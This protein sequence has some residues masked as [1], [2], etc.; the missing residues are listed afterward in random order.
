MTESRQHALQDRI[1]T[2]RIR[3]L[4]IEF[5]RR[6]GDALK[7]VDRV[8]IDIWPREIVGIIGESGSGKTLT[9][10]AT[11]RM[12]PKRAVI[13]KGTMHLGETSLHDRSER[14]MRALRGDR[15]ALIP[16]DAMQ[17]LNPTMRIGRQVGEPL[18]LHSGYSV[19]SALEAAGKLLGSVHIREP[20]KRVLEYPHQ[21]SGGMQQRAMIA[22]GLALNPQLIIAD[23]PTTAL[24]VT[25]QAQVLKLLREIRD[26]KG[27][28]ILFITHDLGVVAE[29]C[30]WVYVM[31]NG[32]IV[33]DGAVRQIFTAPR[34]E[35]TRMLLDATPS[36]HTTPAVAR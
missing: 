30:D 9:S 11:L 12:L 25:V 13:A 3:D 21:Y 28:S 14:E 24:D 35:Y 8:S 15:I 5:A 32:E 27:A 6:R 16:Q 4:S 33:E 36:I 17:S 10:L 26:Q 19:S 2:L 18:E 31:R 1:P 34:A 22:M 7:V 23:E 29:L 20:E